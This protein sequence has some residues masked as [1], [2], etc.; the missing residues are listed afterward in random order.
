MTAHVVLYDAQ[1]KCVA[2]LH[3]TLRDFIDEV[4]GLK[5]PDAVLDALHVVSTIS[6]PLNVLG[7]ARFPRV[8][9]DWG[10]IKLG[11]SVLSPREHSQGM[12]GRIRRARGQELY[13]SPVPGEDQPSLVHLDR[14][15]ASARTYWC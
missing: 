15:Q 7:A 8:A 12:V 4:G 10:S 2:D 14:N 3:M 11:K 1:Q 6:L 9:T 5:T 13:T